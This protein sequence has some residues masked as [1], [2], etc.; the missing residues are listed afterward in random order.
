MKYTMNWDLES[1]FPGGSASLALK[2]KINLM[3]EQII[4]YTAEVTSWNPQL[5]QP[6]YTHLKTILE[7]EEKIKYGLTQSFSFINAVQSANVKD[8]QSGAI[9]GQLFELNSQFATSETIFIKKMVEIP[10]EEW[11]KLIALPDFSPIK[12]NLSEN[13]QHGKEL[14]SEAEEALINALS[15]DGFEAWSKHYDTLV[16]TIEIPFE[17]KDGTTTLL[18]A[19]QAFN[20]MTG[21]PDPLV[22]DQL[23][24]QWEATW[25]KLAPVFADT[26]NHLV[27]FRLATYKAHGVTDFLKRPLEYN[28]MKP[29]TLDAMWQAVSS[30]KTAFVDYLNRKAKLFGKEKLDWQDLDAPIII[31][32]S[33]AQVYPYDE[34]AEFII[35]NFKK[36]S[37][38]MADF[39][40]M[41]FDN[42]W[43]E[44]EDRPGKRPGGYCTSLPESGESR[45]FMTYSES[46]SEVSTLAHELGH[47]FH[48]YVMKD[49]PGVSQEYAMN[50][51]E[52][53]STFA[54][55]IVADATVKEAKDDAEKIALLDTKMSSALAMFLNIHAR[56][57][58]ETNFYTERQEGIVSFERLS[59][60]M[61]S[62]QKEAYQDSLGS[63][64]P[65]FW[66]SKL[67]FFISDVP[68]YNFPYTFGYLFSL[69]IYARSIEEGAGFEDKYIALLRDTASMTTEELAMKHLGVD[70]TKPD[71]WVAGIKIME[72]DVQTFM[73]LTDSYSK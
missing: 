70:L 31:P 72:Q 35:D 34:G 2:E 4:D 33:K 23:F 26:L 40:Q 60:L 36:F 5:D 66:A 24:S 21:D 46:P 22:R 63:Y 49:L 47:A 53:A 51:A 29:E 18:S 12:F 55:M 41:A 28:R 67:H 10:D 7:K 69:G 1:I 45:I 71:F 20:K 58:F 25:S 17:E 8:T 59:E 54:E 16:G 11:Q 6:T 42:R 50:V 27:G 62:A 73:D 37:P 61:E 13:R 14:L 64:H 43:I 38:K 65:Y 56:F 68:F 39:A 30:H 57:L 15:I 9:F 44:A 32:G 3:T 48:S 19:G 52:T